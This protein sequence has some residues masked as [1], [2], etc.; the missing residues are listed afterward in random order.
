MT[1]SPSFKFLSPHLIILSWLPDIL[2]DIFPV[3]WKNLWLDIWQ[4]FST[5]SYPIS[6]KSLDNLLR[7]SVCLKASAGKQ[8]CQKLFADQGKSPSLPSCNMGFSKV[9]MGQRTL[10]CINV[11]QINMRDIYLNLK[12]SAKNDGRAKW[13]M[14]TLIGNWMQGQKFSS[15][16]PPLFCVKKLNK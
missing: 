6:S 9:Y 7:R 4:H 15:Y 8:S 5:Q 14:S 13:S 1:L 3:T 10:T 2:I 12:W 11:V 16:P